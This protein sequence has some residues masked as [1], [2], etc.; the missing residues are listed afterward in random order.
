M[1]KTALVMVILGLC[2]IVNAVTLFY[3][4]A[5]MLINW[6]FDWVF[7]PFL[8]LSVVFIFTVSVISRYMEKKYIEK[9]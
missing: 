2:I 7:I 8:I 1:N 9:K 3:Y 5:T 4:G 6:R